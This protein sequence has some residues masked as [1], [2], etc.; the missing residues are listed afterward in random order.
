[1]HAGYDFQPDRSSMPKRV[2]RL[3]EPAGALDRLPARSG[4]SGKE[5]GEPS[6]TAIGR[7]LANLSAIALPAAVLTPYRETVLHARS[8]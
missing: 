5:H 2:S 4:C 8:G 6:R 3:V 7:R 1:M